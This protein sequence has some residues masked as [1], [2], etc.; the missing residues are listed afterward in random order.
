MG[1]AGWFKKK[2]KAP[3]E[4]RLAYSEL[5]ESSKPDRGYFVMIAISAVIATLGLFLD[6]VAVIIGAMLIAPL[7]SPVLATGLAVARGDPEFLTDSLKAGAQG[8]VVAVLCAAA[9]A[10]ISP[11]LAPGR[12]ILS[13]VK[14]NLFDL[15]V[16]FASGVA[17]AYTFS[18]KD[19]SAMLPG[20]AIAAALIPPLSVAGIGIGFGQHEIMWGALLLFLANLIAIAFGAAVTFI[21]LG[22]YPKLKGSEG[23][24]RFKGLVAATVL[25]A[26]VTIPMAY[27]TITNV[28]TTSRERNVGAVVEEYLPAREGY[29][30]GAVDWVYEDGRYEVTVLV[31]GSCLPSDE[32][33]KLVQ[34]ALEDRLGRKTAV[35]IRCVVY[36]DFALD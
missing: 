32:R 1:I 15:M 22:F 30:V 29:H 9:I 11:E 17:G 4:S 6:S 14:P 18:S 3:P 25:V 33:L 8:A 28:T 27:F 23:E 5:R 2:V 19:L 24:W 35:H 31:Y 21:V 7:M 12:E 10:V 16:A 13:R 20:V 34:G 26:L 36:E